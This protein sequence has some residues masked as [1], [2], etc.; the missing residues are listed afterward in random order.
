MNIS[1]LFHTLIKTSKLGGGDCRSNLYKNDY[2]NN[3]LVLQELCLYWSLWGD[4]AGMS[5][6]KY[7]L[8][9]Y[10][11]DFMR[12]DLKKKLHSVYSYRF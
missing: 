12:D 11:C 9:C 1:L 8:F 5:P 7:S 4:K 3:T 6:N 10:L 2:S